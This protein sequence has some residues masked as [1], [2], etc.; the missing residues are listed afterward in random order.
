M[1][2][3]LRFNLT[4]LNDKTFK[5]KANSD[6]LSEEAKKLQ[7]TAVAI[8]FISKG[9]SKKTSTY[10]ENLKQ[11]R[12]DNYN[13]KWYE[14][15]WYNKGYEPRNLINFYYTS[16][17]NKGQNWFYKK[18]A[19]PYTDKTSTGV[20][21]DI[22][23]SGLRDD[24]FPSTGED[25][26]S[27]FVLGGFLGTKYDLETFVF[28]YRN[29]N[30]FF[31]HNNIQ[32]GDMGHNM[33]YDQINKYMPGEDI[34]F[35]RIFFE[36]GLKKEDVNE[37]TKVIILSHSKDNLPFSARGVNI[38]TTGTLSNRKW[39]KKIEKQNVPRFDVFF[40]EQE[41]ELVQVPEQNTNENFFG[42]GPIL[43]LKNPSYSNFS[44]DNFS[45]Q[46]SGIY[47]EILYKTF[48]VY[49][50]GV[51]TEKFY[52][53][54]SNK[55]IVNIIDFNKKDALKPSINP[56]YIW[57]DEDFSTRSGQ[58]IKVYELGKN[59]NINFNL[60]INTKYLKNNLNQIHT[61]YVNIYRVTG[62]KEVSNSPSFI[63]DYGL[64]N[65]KFTFPV[66]IRAIDN[67]TKITHTNFF[68]KGKNLSI[69]NLGV[70]PFTLTKTGI[71]GKKTNIFNITFR[72][73]GENIKS[74]LV[75]NDIYNR[76]NKLGP[77][78]GQNIKH[79]YPILSGEAYL[80]STTNSKWINLSVNE[81][82]NFKWSQNSGLGDL[83][84]NL[85]INID[86][87]EMLPNFS[88]SNGQNYIV[89][90]DQNLNKFLFN[91]SEESPKIF[92]NKNYR[93]LFTNFS[94]NNF[95]ILNRN[96]NYFEDYKIYEPEYNKVLQ[97]YKLL[98]FRLGIGG[99]TGN[100]T[101][102]GN[103]NNLP[104]TGEFKVLNNENYNPCYLST[105][106]EE[107][108]I[109]NISPTVK[110][111]SNSFVPGREQ[112]KTALDLPLFT[113]DFLNKESKINFYPSVDQNIKIINYKD[114]PIEQNP[115]RRMF[116]NNPKRFWYLMTKVEFSPDRL[117]QLPN[118]AERLTRSLESN[119]L[120]PSRRD[121]ITRVLSGINN[122]IENQ[123]AS[124]YP[125][126]TGWISGCYS[127]D[128][129]LKFLDEQYSKKKTNPFI[130]FTTGKYYHFVRPASTEKEINNLQLEFFTLDNSINKF[131][132][133]IP[134]V[135]ILRDTHLTDPTYLVRTFNDTKTKYF[136]H[137]HF[138]VPA[139]VDK[140][141]RYFYGLKHDITGNDEA[142][143]AISQ[144]EIYDK[145]QEV[146]VPANYIGQIPTPIFSGNLN[147]ITSD[148][149]KGEIN[150]P[151]VLSGI[152]GFDHIRF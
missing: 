98:Q 57:T 53:N 77:Y 13:A 88:N 6:F 121:E 108:F 40:Y 137:I 63:N 87:K 84:C 16:K 19:L 68:E 90:F 31:D 122:F 86:S 79:I 82:Q 20:Y 47:P 58:F 142:D 136:D 78:T 69:N 105:G 44:K 104:I 102:S 14:S 56:S 29:F 125:A 3:K 147:F 60:K 152:S 73:I 150:M 93:F 151:L 75:R 126:V 130:N 39:F 114:D 25:R 143:I 107:Y 124:D 10:K 132:K 54:A 35:N 139:T 115:C 106:I 91:G 131:K 7:Q 128:E 100:L 97:N 51:K 111:Y 65:E 116:Y 5:E 120:S 67:G 48:C 99:I 72:S 135:N 81:S 8:N 112:L 119:L 76:I 2:P 42:Y 62:R 28:P 64:L 27:N 18:N 127:D 33:F 52:L 117:Y 36:K 1:D 15:G 22:E 41:L 38:E 45:V 74:E 101:W 149:N 21:F 46:V 146:Y 50:T 89:K 49:N 26:L 118:L 103:I 109:Y 4:A 71:L 145:S 70:G 92:K 94:D 96:E 80:N 134:E 144:I 85:F 12:I 138:Y 83:E 32:V 113:K 95:N 66:N 23:W 24:Y 17:P 61:E 30:E 34:G 123:N 140:S 110:T 148:V 37:N 133:G 141:K 9:F 129:Y 59:G 43:E 11:T 55:D